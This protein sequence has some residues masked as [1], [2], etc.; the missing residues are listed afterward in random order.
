LGVE[1]LDRM[2]QEEVI[3]QQAAARGI[4]VTEAEVDEALREEIA[5]S[6]GAV[7]VPHATATAEAA[8]A[9]TATAT[10]WTPTPSPTVDV[11]STVTATATPFP[12]PVPPTPLP[13]L[14][15]EQYQ[16]GL[17]TV[18]SNLREVAGM[19]LAEYRRIIEARL[20]SEKLAEVIGAEQVP[21]TQEQV[22]ARHILLNIVT[23][24]PEPTP[25]P[26]GAATPEPTLTP[27]PLPEGFP[28]PEPTPGPRDDAATLALAQELRQRL[29]DGEDFAA[30][31]A[32]YSDDPSNAG[33]G[34]DLGWF[35]RGAMVAPFEEAAFSLEPG[36]LS[37]PVKTEYG[38]HLIEVLEK[39]AERPKD[40]ATLE[41]ER[42]QAF[43]TWLQEQVAATAIER[44]SDLMAKLP[45]GLEVALPQLAPPEQA[46][47]VAQPEIATTAP[48]T[49]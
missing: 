26:E 39:D 7:T 35:A 41:Q 40:P 6:Q 38:Y 44:P 12:T 18:E 11:S 20:L 10:S 27:T 8:V 28:T 9:A 33:T 5:G 32:E 31:A 34:G 46:P 3:R 30:L 13:I 16:E 24:T 29:V 23:P 37:E 21:A 43:Q 47:P 42:A 36:T 2:I 48:I 19:S 25:L 15:D 49:Q 17:A 14:T 22:H 1:V 45:R 4:T